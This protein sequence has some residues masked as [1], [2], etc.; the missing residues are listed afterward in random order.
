M[1]TGDI[2]F[3]AKDKYALLL[4]IAHGDL[5]VNYEGCPKSFQEIIRKCLQ[6][7]P[8]K[9][10]SAQQLLHESI[11]A[12]NSSP[13]GEPTLTASDLKAPSQA[14]AA[15]EENLLSSSQPG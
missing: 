15:K 8:S 13:N 9:R 11:F 6:K 5:E 10:P 3:R 12:A 1:V 2:P 7:N 4:Q 14:S